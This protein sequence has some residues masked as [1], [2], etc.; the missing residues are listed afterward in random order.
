MQ[1]SSLFYVELTEKTLDSAPASRW[2][3]TGPQGCIARSLAICFELLASRQGQL[4]G[5]DFSGLLKRPRLAQLNAC[6][7]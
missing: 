1:E 6:K 3:M 4:N 2:A 5:E 7:T